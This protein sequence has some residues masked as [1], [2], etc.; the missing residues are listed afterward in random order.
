M[1][2]LWY[3]VF[4]LQTVFDMKIYMNII[5]VKAYM[6]IICFTLFYTH[7]LLLVCGD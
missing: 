5:Y 2:I 4:F 1:S 3:F 7:F 6:N